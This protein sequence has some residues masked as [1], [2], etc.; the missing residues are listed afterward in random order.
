MVVG[1]SHEHHC[2]AHLLLP[3]HERSMAQAHPEWSCQYV[4]A[5][6]ARDILHH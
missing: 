6:P 1:E 2:E 5:P 4:C 3:Q